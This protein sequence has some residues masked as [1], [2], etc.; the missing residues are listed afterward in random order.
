ME[1]AFILVHLIIHV[2]T[3]YDHSGHKFQLFY[4][5]RQH[6]CKYLRL[7]IAAQQSNKGSSER[8]IEYRVDNW[9]YRRRHI[10]EPQAH[11]HHVVGNRALRTDGED[12]VQH[13]ERRPAQNER[14]EHDAKDLRYKGTRLPS[15]FKNIIIMHR[16]RQDA[17]HSVCYSECTFE[18]FRSVATAFADKLPRLLRRLFRNLLTS[19][20]KTNKHTQSIRIRNEIHS[21]SQMSCGQFKLPDVKIHR[22]PC[23]ITK[24]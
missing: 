17:M 8:S 6:I 2:Q 10:A 1:I 15:T 7:A 11:A 3:N 20:R 4:F 21:Q 18:A 19:V 13:E 14:E 5:M 24:L 23:H 16:K 22:W 12:D 9:I